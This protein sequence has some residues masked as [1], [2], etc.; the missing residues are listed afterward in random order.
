MGTRVFAS[1]GVFS[2][3]VAFFVVS[4]SVVT[5]PIYRIPLGVDEMLPQKQ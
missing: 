1:V 5:S 4:I 2:M 3:I